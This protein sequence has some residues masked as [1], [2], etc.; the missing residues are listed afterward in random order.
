MSQLA[1]CPACKR[2]VATTETACPFCAAALP[3]SFR[4]RAPALRRPG[5]LS[6]AAMLAASAALL[7]AEA[8]SDDVV[9]APA[10]GVPPAPDAA[11]DSGTTD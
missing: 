1:P 3:D 6:R 2:H 4:Q 11:T 7:G 8:C 9:V 10:Y 5:R